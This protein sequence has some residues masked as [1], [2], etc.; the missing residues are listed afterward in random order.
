MQFLD[1]MYFIENYG[2]KLKYY[3]TFDVS[4]E[5]MNYSDFIFPEFTWSLIFPFNI[6]IIC[7][8]LFKNY[9]LMHISGL[10]LPYWTYN[11]LIQSKQPKICMKNI[12]KSKKF[13]RNDW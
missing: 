12:L 1:F 5:F 7:Q 6:L 3:V 11:A 4:N 2:I 9:N 10:F 8:N 13:M